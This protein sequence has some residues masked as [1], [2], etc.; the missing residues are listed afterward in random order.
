MT[1]SI[2]RE[3]FVGKSKYLFC[4]KLNCEPFKSKKV[5]TENWY[6]HLKGGWQWGAN[7]QG[8]KLNK[9]TLVPT[10]KVFFFKRFQ[11][12]KNSEIEY[13][14]LIYSTSRVQVNLFQKTP[15]YN[16]K[17]KDLLSIW[18]FWTI[19]FFCFFQYNYAI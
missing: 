5:K 4:Y 7:E 1:G 8:I 6:D 3:A 13:I 2:P 16:I 17:L 12:I 10:Y 15:T 19:S 9:G 11:Y 18:V 14:L